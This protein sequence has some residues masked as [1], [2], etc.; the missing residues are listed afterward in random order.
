MADKTEHSAVA[1]H[2]RRTWP[3]LFLLVLAVVSLLLHIEKS[4]RQKEV[5]AAK[6]QYSV[7]VRGK[8]IEKVKGQRGR[9]YKI[10]YYLGY[11]STTSHA[12]ADFVRR[13]SAA[14]PLH[15]VRDLQIDPGLQN[16]SFR[17]TLGIA[18]GGTEPARLAF[19][20]CFEK[21]QSNSD[22]TRIAF[23]EHS[24][25]QAAENGNRVYVFS[26]TGQVEL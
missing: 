4:R 12:L 21:L 14:I 16:F 2:Y 24:A 10:Q 8:P 1:R 25:A 19:A 23:E 26:I 22:I 13:L 11:P 18:A 9:F 3:L 7:L 5:M 15:Q 17:L 6:Q 20:A